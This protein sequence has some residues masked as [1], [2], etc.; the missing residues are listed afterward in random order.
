MDFDRGFFAVNNQMISF[1][2]NESGWP[3]R[4]LMM[5][6]IL[7]ALWKKAFRSAFHH[8]QFSADN[9]GN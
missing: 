7:R 4:D 5:K 3:F 2:V 1:Y 9:W 6:R 8:L